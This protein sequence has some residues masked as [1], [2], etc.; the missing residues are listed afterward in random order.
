MIA[1]LRGNEVSGRGV[2]A[3]AQLQ[4][5]DP[6]QGL[7]EGNASLVGEGRHV[8]DGDLL[9]P[10][11]A[12]EQTVEA[13]LGLEVPD[14]KVSQLPRLGGLT[15]RARRHEFVVQARENGHAVELAEERE[16]PLDVVS[17]LE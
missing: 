3:V 8:G 14:E 1:A 6:V 13:H 7:L 10:G 15:A 2:S 17:V 16:K 9:T 11:K 5:I 4:G 12:L